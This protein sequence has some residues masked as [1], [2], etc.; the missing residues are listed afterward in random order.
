MKMQ[1]STR[2]TGSPG[3]LVL[4]LFLVISFLLRATAS[5]V[6]GY[7]KDKTT[8]VPLAGVKLS[9]ISIGNTSLKY[10]LRTDGK[11]IFVKTGLPKGMYRLT[12]EKEGYLPVQT[13]ISLKAAALFDPDLRLEIIKPEISGTASGLIIASDKLMRAG[14]YDEA[15]EKL[16][17]AIGTEPENFILYYYRARLY[18]KK[19]DNDKAIGDYKKSVQLKPDFLIAFAALGISYVKQEEF[20]DAAFYFK[21]AFDLDITD[22]FSLYN[23]GGCL[24]HLGKIH[25]ARTVFEKVVRLDNG[26]AEAYYQLG[27][28]YLGL[29]DNSKAREC[30][31]I[32]VR[33][34]P[35]NN[36]ASIAREI[37]RT[38]E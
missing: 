32:F 12:A 19:S 28:I 22:T 31:G 14:K 8:G 2:R 17:Q 29:N 6:R 7:V 25:D 15:I 3:I 26:Y 21:K 18:E 36:N 35:G 27:L 30:L 4:F 37:L 10:Q 20:A 1:A 11:G 13:T 23:Y 24:I 33:L 9:L 16:N 5:T 34:D 38:L